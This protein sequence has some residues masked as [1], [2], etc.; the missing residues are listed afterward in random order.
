M[1]HGLSNRRDRSKNISYFLMIKKDLPYQA[2]IVDSNQ[3]WSNYHPH[4]IVTLIDSGLTISGVCL[5]NLMIERK[6]RLYA[7]RLIYL[8]NEF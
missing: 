1:A 2:Q 8:A 7:T 4:P 3:S 6:T 5:T